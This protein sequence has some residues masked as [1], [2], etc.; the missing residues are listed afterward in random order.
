M[1]IRLY[2]D[3][4]AMR[5]ALV[6]ALRTEGID[7]TFVGEQGREGHSD[8]QQLEYATAEGRVLYS[9]NIRDY[10]VLHAQFLEEGRPHAGIIV[11]DQHRRYSVGEQLRR[12]Q[13]LM[14]AKSAEEMRNQLVYLSA[15]G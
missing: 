3:E 10:V 8:H 13:A 7:V 14:K 15:W 9:F 12:V 2:I 1:K 11:T 4:D 6:L 5:N